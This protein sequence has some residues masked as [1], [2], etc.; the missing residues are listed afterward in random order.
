MRYFKTE[1]FRH[2][3][4]FRVRVIATVIIVA[5]AITMITRLFP[6]SK[7]DLGRCVCH[8]DGY[9]QLCVTNGRDTVVVRQD[10][11]SQVGVWADKHWWWPS[12]RGR[13]LTV[14]QGE[15]S[16]CEADRRNVDNI[17]QKINIV[18][19]SIKRIIAR[20]E[21]EQ[22]EINY[23]FRSHGVQDEGY[24]KIAQHA[25]RQKKETDSLKRTFLILKKYKPRHGDTLKRRY[26]LWVSWRDR[27][28][29]L[30]TEKCKEAITDV[31]C[32]GEPFVVQT[33]QKTKPRGVYAVRN[34]PW[35]V[36]RKTNVITV[37]PVAPNAVMKREAVLVPGRSVDGRLRDVPELFAQDGSPVF[38]A[39]GEFLGLVYKNRIARIKK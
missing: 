2:D 21:I 10:S 19:D 32:A 31:A 4:L 33:C 6:A 23:Y 11:I 20:N 14:A 3:A 29:K 25:E 30:Q 13:V 34:I 9:S 8:V 22:K 17:E 5:V 1:K 26:L 35:R 28:G 15:P 27:D 18:T 39:Y 12:C 38:N 16:T 36:C 37:T 24:M 7:D